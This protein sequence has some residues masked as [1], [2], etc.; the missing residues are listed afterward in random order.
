MVI[1]STIITALNNFIGWRANGQSKNCKRAIAGLLF[2]ALAALMA[3]SVSADYQQK[4]D[5]QTRAD[6]RSGRDIRYQY[7]VRFYPQY[8]FDDAYSVHA[9][10]ATGDDFASSHNTVDD[11]DV[12]FFYLRRAYLRHSGDYGK[13]EFGVI[14]TYKG[15]V[16]SSGLSKDGW[17][18]GIRHVRQ[19]DNDS[20][21]EIVVGQLDNL[22]P[23]RALDAPDKI[24]YVEL[25]YSA[26]MS[27]R[28]SFEFS[29]E[30]MTD[31]NF[32]RTEYRYQINDNHLVF[33]E[34]VKQVANSQSKVVLGVEGELVFW[35]QP[36]EY[37]SYYSYVS[38]D[39]GLRAELTEDFI[40][41]GNGF[42]AKFSADIDT[43]R[44]SWFVRF[45]HVDS[46]SRV[47][48]GLSWK[49]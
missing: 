14:P 4:I 2:A 48:A 33:T 21:F 23:A 43:L 1:N 27:Q 3:P 25:E 49:L 45:D 10:A 28:N 40:D 24:D 12:D 16:S 38:N 22:N 29:L 19:F 36:I 13:T 8:S 9:F 11:G 39:F 30:R 44:G 15:R 5:V 46:R 42:S 35:Q 34:W 32:I 31:A 41:V 26:R 6:D 18:S 7:R 20:Q 37:F 17:I 47:L